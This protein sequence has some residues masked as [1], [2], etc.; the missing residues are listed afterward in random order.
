MKKI[1]SILLAAV[2]SFSVF[3]L[4]CVA[5]ESEAEKFINESIE[6]KS[7]GFYKEWVDLDIVVISSYREEYKIFEESDGDHSLKMK[8]SGKAS[9]FGLPFFTQSFE[10]IVSEEGAYAYLPGLR[11]KCDLSLLLDI[12]TGNLDI[13]SDNFL[14]EEFLVLECVETTKKTLDNGITLDVE[15]M[16][17]SP[18]KYVSYMI[19]SGDF[20]VDETIDPSAMTEDE[21]CQIIAEANNNTVENVKALIET[22]YFN[23]YVNDG[24]VYLIEHVYLDSEG[25]TVTEPFFI[26]GL[27]DEGIDYMYTGISED[28][29]DH[30]PLYIDATGLVIAIMFFLSSM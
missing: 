20:D 24:N 8:I 28:E 27:S 6:T 29:F 15:K 18:G 21:L 23:F 13:D 12:S 16:V 26:E 3:G 4:T 7:I 30:H 1:V 10:A 5:E 19:N 2:M 14:T 9:L 22:S 25:Q 11:L 17:I